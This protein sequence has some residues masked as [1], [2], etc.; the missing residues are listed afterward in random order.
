[1]H[2][3]HLAKADSCREQAGVFLS[4][5]GTR[6]WSHSDILDGALRSRTEVAHANECEAIGGHRVR[7]MTLVTG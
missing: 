7:L 3:P 5:Q 4:V 1:M 6:R 2:L